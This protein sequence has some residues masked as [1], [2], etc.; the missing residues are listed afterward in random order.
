MLPVLPSDPTIVTLVEPG[1]PVRVLDSYTENQQVHTTSRPFG[2]QAAQARAPLLVDYS[3]S[4][5][6]LT[7]CTG[8]LQQSFDGGA[9][10]QDIGVVVDLFANPQGN[11]TTFYAVAVLVSGPIYKFRI[12]TL[13]ATSITIDVAVS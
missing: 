1:I 2:F 11:L 7:V 9:T 3:V 10:F 13:T 5:V 8:F 6:N 12:V 4:G